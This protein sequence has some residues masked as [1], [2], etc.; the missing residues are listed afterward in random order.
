MQAELNKMVL[1]QRLFSIRAELKHSISDKAVDQWRLRG[2]RAFATR[3]STLNICLIESLLFV[4]NFK[5]TDL[6]FL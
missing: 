1:A 5:L 3:D 2:G 4:L 6:I